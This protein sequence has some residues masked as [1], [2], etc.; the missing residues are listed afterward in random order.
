MKFFQQPYYVGILS[1]AA[2]HGAAHQQ[3]QVFQVMTDKPLRPVKVGDF[4][5]KFYTKKQISSSECQSVKTVTGYMQVA[6]PEITAFDLV[7]YIKPAGYLNN[8]ATVLSELQERFDKS[9]F[10]KIFEDGHLASPDV[11]RLGYLLELIE[12]NQ[13][14]ISL[15]KT[16]LHKRKIRPVPLRTDKI[17]EN[18]TR[19]EEW[20]LY[21]NEK[22]EADL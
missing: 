10:E 12:A 8:V 18:T 5:I 20:Q 4:F 19:N 9:R 14:I 1:A 16:W 15:F 22:I 21:I 17:Y 13:E 2:L 6:T 11:Q 3:P 7:R